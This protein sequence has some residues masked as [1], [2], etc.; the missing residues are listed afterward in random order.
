M[1]NETDIYPSIY[2]I[3][4]P[5]HLS[6][7]H[8]SIYI[9]L[10]FACISIY[11]SDIHGCIYYIYLSDIYLSFGIHVDLSDIRRIARKTW[12][13]VYLYIWCLP[14]FLISMSFYLSDI[15]VYLS[16]WYPCLSIY[17]IFVS[18]YLSNIYLSLRSRY[19]VFGLDNINYKKSFSCLWSR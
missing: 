19:I 14:I 5:I 12:I 3:F 1:F 9:Y 4:I 18:I 7:I 17:L 6:D 15:R 16:F 11:L 10:I 13:S 2:L 8:V